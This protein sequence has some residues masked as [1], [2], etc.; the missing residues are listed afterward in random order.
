MTKAGF[1]VSYL[2]AFCYV[3]H[4][5]RVTGIWAVSGRGGGHR[6][7]WFA[8]EY[9]DHL[10]PSWLPPFYCNSI[11]T[12]RLWISAT[13]GQEQYESHPGTQGPGLCFVVWLLGLQKVV[14]SASLLP[15]HHWHIPIKCFLLFLC[16]L[17]FTK[18]LYQIQRGDFYL[19]TH[20][21]LRFH[22][23]AEI[24]GKYWFLMA[25]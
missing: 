21:T 6:Q 23:H 20:S 2:W 3:R 16:H 1:R 15:L 14:A 9:F 19:S 22:R 5:E 25:R 12:R 4:W 17:H 13:R 7:G 8:T 11:S 18:L 24:C 10:I